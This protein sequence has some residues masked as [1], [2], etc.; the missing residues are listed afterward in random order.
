MTPSGVC[1]CG[2]ATVPMQGKTTLV[3]LMLGQLNP[4]AG[5]VQLNSGARVA[6]VNQ[7]H[8]DQID[9]DQTPLDYLRSQFRGRG[10]DAGS[11]EWEGKL[12]AHLSSCGIASE[13]QLV[14]GRALSGGQRSRLAMA[15]V[16]LQQPHVL[17]LDEPTNN[18]DLEA[19]EALAVAVTQFEGSVVIVSH[20]QFFVSQVATEVYVVE[21]RRVTK[22][23][24]FQAYLA[25]AHAR[26]DAVA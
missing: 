16:S 2:R 24:S 19:V 4:T 8:A 11:R 10:G 5:H 22:V 9:L 6:L 21:G 20:D 7:H 18:L 14:P 26:A 23:P 17:I 13:L 12:R 25:A 15:C 1:A 3:K